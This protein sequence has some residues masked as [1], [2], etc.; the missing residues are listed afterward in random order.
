MELHHVADAV[1]VQEEV[2]FSINWRSD[3]TTAY[4]ICYNDV[5]GILR[6]WIHL[7][8]IKGIFRCI[9]K[10]VEQRMS[11]IVYLILYEYEDFFIIL[12]DFIEKSADMCYIS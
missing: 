8:G 4:V 6:A 5:C 1:Q 11:N 12:P 2:L 3:V 7:K 9:A 10:E